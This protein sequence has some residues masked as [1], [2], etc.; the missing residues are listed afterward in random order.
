MG[1]AAKSAE[2]GTTQFYDAHAQDYS[3]S[4]VRLDLRALREPF[5]KALRPGS[6]ILDAGCGSGRDSKAFLDGGY[7]VTAIDASHELARLA[8]A[9]TGLPSQVLSFQEM[10][11]REEF[12]GIWACASL[13]HV[14][15]RDINNVMTRFVQALKPGGVFYISLKEGQGERIAEDG[16][17]F[18]YYTLESFRELLAS[19]PALGEASVW[20]TPE[21]RSLNHREPWLNFL[22]SKATK[23]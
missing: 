1:Q 21:I 20:K 19:Y 12:D 8:T 10:Q 11:F 14:P 2:A 13:L 9:Y 5:L 22:L 15:P 4:T 17:F 18:N 6:H 3:E 16:R 23:I 7:R